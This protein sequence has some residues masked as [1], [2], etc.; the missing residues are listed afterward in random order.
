MSRE[1]L[2][3]TETA[4]NKH[5]A[6]AK[7]KIAELE[8]RLD[9]LPSDKG[10]TL[11]PGGG[12]QPLSKGEQKTAIEKEIAQVKESTLNAIDQKLKDASPDDK[13]KCEH[14]VSQWLYPDR[15]DPDQEKDLDASQTMLAKDMYERK[16]PEK[17][18]EKGDVKTM[19][20]AERS[21]WRQRYKEEM[22]EPET[23][24]KQPTKEDRKDL[25]ASQDFA[26]R[27]RYRDA[28]ES[29]ETGPEM[30]KDD[31]KEDFELDKD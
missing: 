3:A 31:D 18:L 12:P 6:D 11:K 29:L 22:P 27:L 1:N 2:S 7:N 14:A 28:A 25:D 9:N 26:F 24:Q 15:I 20:Q 8:Q 13:E 5:M 17:P 30:D 10:P 19:E 21:M 4:V 23:V 16:H